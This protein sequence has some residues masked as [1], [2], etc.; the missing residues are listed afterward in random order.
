MFA[1][2]GESESRAVEALTGPLLRLRLY[3]SQKHQVQA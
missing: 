3:Q 1:T 2:F